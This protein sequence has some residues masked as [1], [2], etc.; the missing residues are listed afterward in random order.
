[1]IRSSIFL[2]CSLVSSLLFAQ[3]LPPYNP[4]TAERLLN[5]EE[6]NWL[7]YRGSYD[8]HGFSNLDQINTENVDGLV[9]IWSFS[10]GLREGHQAPPI[11]N[12][13]YMYVTTPQNHILA[14]NA[15]TGY[16]IW[17]YV[18]YLPDDLQQFHPTNR[19]VALFGDRVYMATVDSFLVS[20]DA[21]TGELIWEVAVEDYYNG[22][23]MTMATL[24]ADGKVMV[25]V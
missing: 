12:D 23:Y 2:C 10:T 3:D 9:P 8:S 22:Y 14:I 7:M 16:L 19:G 25:G 20:L 1:M 24:I 17:R 13:G 15:R 11:V 4:V 21:L 18:R 5:P 6:S